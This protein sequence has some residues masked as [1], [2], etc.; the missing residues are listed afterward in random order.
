MT[1]STTNTTSHVSGY[2]KRMDKSIAR[3]NSHIVSMSKMG[4]DSIETLNGLNSPE[5]VLT[6][7]SRFSSSEDN[8]NNLRSSMP[9]FTSQ[10]TADKLIQASKEKGFEG[11]RVRQFR[12]GDDTFGDDDE[13]DSSSDG[14]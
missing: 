8:I 7:D 13:S 12:Q 11:L 6:C 9:I 5:V 14:E 3:I 2:T 10:A 1:D 4:I